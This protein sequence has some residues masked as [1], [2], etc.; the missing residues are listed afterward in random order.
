MLVA[1]SAKAVV[2]ADTKIIG[3]TLPYELPEFSKLQRIV[4][5]H[6]LQRHTAC[7]VS[8]SVSVRIECDG[9]GGNAP[10]GGV[11]LYQRGGLSLGGE[12]YIG[13]NPPEKF[14]FQ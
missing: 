5:A 2:P 6:V 7:L 4:V 8:R 10:I 14:C 12:A 3:V 9:H 1:Y 11:A 13:L